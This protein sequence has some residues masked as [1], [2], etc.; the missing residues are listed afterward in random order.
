[1]LKPGISVHTGCRILPAQP[2]TTP[3]VWLFKFCF[4]SLLIPVVDAMTCSTAS[5]SS[6]QQECLDSLAW[7]LL[8]L[9][10]RVSPA[11][12]RTANDAQSREDVATRFSMSVATLLQLQSRPVSMIGARPCCG[13]RDEVHQAYS[14]A[15]SGPTG[16][17]QYASV[18]RGE[19]PWSQRARLAAD[20]PAAPVPKG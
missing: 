8:L 6:G 19:L 1:M 10:K 14:A 2:P 20:H 13:G 12:H 9:P 11:R 5:G 16:R 17:S 15:G 7:L 3:A 18:R 4:R